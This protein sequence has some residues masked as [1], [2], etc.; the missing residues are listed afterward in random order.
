VLPYRAAVPDFA[1]AREGACEEI[2]EG[3]Q[4]GLSHQG[5]HARLRGLR[6][7]HHSIRRFSPPLMGFAALNPSYEAFL[8]ALEGGRNR[9]GGFIRATI[10]RP[11]NR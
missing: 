8:H 4:D 1:I 11:V 2:V 10:F 3:L 9:P 7:T 5:V 6:E